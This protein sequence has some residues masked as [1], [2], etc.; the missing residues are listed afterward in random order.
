MSKELTR[1][2]RGINEGLRSHFCPTMRI[3]ATIQHPDGYAVKVLDGCYLDPIY[4]RVS[5]WWTWQRVND[6][7]TLGEP[8]SGYG[9]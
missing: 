1:I 8:V 2:S 9:W 6:D 4:N 3:G 5:N 7:G